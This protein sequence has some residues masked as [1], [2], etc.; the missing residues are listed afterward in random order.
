MALNNHILTLVEPSI[1]L[2]RFNYTPLKDAEGIT[3]VNEGMGL[4]VPLVIINNYNFQDEDIQSL[5]I[6]LSGPLPV[7]NVTVGDSQGKFMVDTFPRD[8][9]TISVRIGA[10]QKNVYKDIRIEFDIT[11]VQMPP[12]SGPEIG[13]NA[14]KYTFKGMMK[15]PGIFADKCIAYE[16][17]NSIE[18]M[19]KIANELGL[20]LATN[21]EMANDTMKFIVAYENMLDA[22]KNRVE[23]SY[24][25]DDSFQ[26]FSVDPYYYIN[27]VDLNAIIN[28]EEDIEQVLTSFANDIDNDTNAGVQFDQDKSIRNIE[29][30]LLLS[31]HENYGDT[32]MHITRFALKNRSGEALRANGYKRNI[33]YFENDSPEGLVNFGI[34]ALTSKQLRDIEEPLKGRRDE[35][36]YKTENKTKYMGRLDT[37]PNTANT[38][39]NY[40][41]ARIHNQQNLDE[42][43]K[44]TLEVELAA[45]NPG[46]HK[47]QKLPIVIYHYTTPQIKASDSVKLAKKAENFDAAATSDDDVQIGDNAT[48]DEFLTGYYVIGDIKYRYSSKVGRIIQVLT[49]LRREWPSRANNIR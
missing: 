19:I 13:S 46:L 38:H 36:R 44:L 22:I 39:I 47:Y 40:N 49:L 24:V 27:Y 21:I 34:E 48:L 32:S 43:K 11:N 29:V 14:V 41:Y 7:I 25:S 28:S 12:K 9:D 18:H 1:K 31:N 23:H 8:G 6:N 10:K 37:D 26:T 2:D 4:E 3:D 42:L 5:E 17:A 35:E 33:E 30:P 20:G 16:S 15:V 45:F